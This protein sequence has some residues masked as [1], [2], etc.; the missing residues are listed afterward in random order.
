MLPV[1]L[2]AYAFVLPGAVERVR[3]A[4]HTTPDLTSPLKIS[5]AA[6]PPPPPAID[7][8]FPD[9]PKPADA[10][11]KYGHD[12]RDGLSSDETAPDP[13][14][15]VAAG[16]VGQIGT[17]G[18]LQ[19]AIDASG[20]SQLVVLKFV[21]DGCLACASTAASYKK[22]AE[23]YGD[24]GQFYEVNFDNS[25]PFCRTAGVKFVPSGHIYAKGSLLK[26]LPLGQKA[27]DD[28]TKELS[29]SREQLK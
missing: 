24:A 29:S 6:A 5:M 11:A 17:I 4:V 14:F 8:R 16:T 22:T 7:L 18:E 12:P 25:K 21:R 28:F 15:T 10:T 20:D 27:W 1:A 2:L 13:A 19:A 3:G 23:S 9:R 26:A